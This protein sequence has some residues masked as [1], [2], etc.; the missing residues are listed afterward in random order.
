MHY[1]VT[2]TVKQVERENP[3]GERGVDK[4]VIEVA[5]VV[6]KHT[7]LGTLMERT[8]AHLDLID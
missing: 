5:H 1:V 6:I 2:L 4:G 8:K 3:P 7:D